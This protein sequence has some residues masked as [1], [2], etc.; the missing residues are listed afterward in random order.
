[1]SDLSLPPAAA[2]AGPSALAERALRLLNRYTFSFALLLTLVLLI[3]NLIRTPDFGWTQQLANFA[4]LAIAAAAST[5][6]ILSGGGGFDLSISPTM[7]L[8]SGL[9]VV[10]LVPAG[11]G[12]Y[13][14]VFFMLLVGAAIGAVN[15][16]LIVGL[17]LL[18]VVVTLSTYFVL[19]G[20]NLKVVSAPESL[21]ITWMN[22]FAGTIAGI[23]GAI[24][25]IAIPLVIWALLGLTSYRRQ[26]Y[27]IGSNDAAAF[28][29]GV[30]VDWV[31]I[32]AYSLGGLIAG[33]GGIAIIAVTSTA[34]A[35]LSETYALQAI[36]AVA[37]GGTSL[38]GGKGGIAGS[39]LGAASIYLLGNLLITLNVNPSWLQ[40]M[41]GAM[42]LLAVM[43]VGAAAN[44]RRAPA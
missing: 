17:R 33:I 22:D 36:A 3:V 23:P 27:A 5:P 25:L 4:P 34:N 19:I 9:Y 16:L 28:S 13:E 43:L 7:V 30:R 29:A 37:L 38:W 44:A 10:W 35:G 18:P 42:L 14:A 39:L 1:M 40:V 24:F 11:M 21:R 20:V 31:R 6:A 26:L 8:T 15:G 2:A 12:G 41:Y 32:L